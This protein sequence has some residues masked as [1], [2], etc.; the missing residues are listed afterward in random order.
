MKKRM[1]LGLVV[2]AVLVGTVYAV[3]VTNTTR[4]FSTMLAGTLTVTSTLTATDRGFAVFP[5]GLSP[6][7]TSSASPVLFSSSFAFASNGVSN[8]H[9]VLNIQLNATTVTPAGTYVVT[10]TFSN[11]GNP[12]VGVSPAVQTVT[13]FVATGSPV[14]PGTGVFCLFDVGAALQPTF[15]YSLTVQSM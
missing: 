8:F 10:L 12:V 7:G 9:W 2:L 1:L 5:I 3:A 4:I 6:Q 13:L 15:A 14:T 11:G